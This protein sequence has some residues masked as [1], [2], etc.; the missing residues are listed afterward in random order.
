MERELSNKLE[1][2][3]SKLQKA[4]AIEHKV[5]IGSKLEEKLVNEAKDSGRALYQTHQT[6]D[7]FFSKG[8]SR[9]SC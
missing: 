8:V 7:H 6:F 5:L 1:K 9:F 4:V 2:T 3:I